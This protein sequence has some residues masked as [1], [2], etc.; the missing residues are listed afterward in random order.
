MFDKLKGVEERFVEVEKLLSDPAIVTDREVYQKYSREHADLSKIVYA[1]RVYK[2]VLKDLD[3]SMELLKDA[4]PDIKELARDEVNALT[5]KMNDCEEKLKKLLVPKDP[6]DEKNVLIEI[7]AGTGGEEAGLFVSD[8]FKMYSKYAENRS[9]KVEV[10]SHH[11]TGI[12]GLKEIIAMVHG[13]GAYSRLKYES[14]THRVQ[15]VPVTETQGRIH[16][17]AVTVAVLPEAEDVELHID[18]SDIKVD[19]YRS[20]GPGGQSVNTTDSAVRITHLASGLVVTCQDEKSQLKNKNKAMK[21]LRARLLDNIIREQNEQRSE[22]RKSQIGSGDR[23]GRIRTYNFAQ[24]RVT[25]HRIGLTLYKLENILH[26][27]IDEIIDGLA[28]HY[29]AKSLQNA[30]SL[31]N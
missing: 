1:F 17:S 26:G 10:M 4:D 7:R 14:G 6:L 19:V 28:T 11:V 20:S 22:E 8:L 15:R 31:K 12:G 5:I 24:G 27:D 9:W 29:Q 13:R 21:V 2:N 16:T 23:S 3:D 25:D 18:P 30:E